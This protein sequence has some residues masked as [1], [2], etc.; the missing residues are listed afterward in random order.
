MKRTDSETMFFYDNWLIPTIAAEYGIDENAAMRNFI[1]SQTYQMLL[2]EETKLYW[3][4]PLVIVDLYKTE[5]ATGN[6][7]NSTYIQTL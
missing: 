7:R 4:S 6:P 1:F 5:M 2:D 3:E